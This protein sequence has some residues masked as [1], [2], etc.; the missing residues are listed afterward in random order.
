MTFF[1]SPFFFFFLLLSSSFFPCCFPP[2]LRVHLFSIVHVV[3][4]YHDRK[5]HLPFPVTFFGKKDY[6]DGLFEPP[7]EVTCV[8]VMSIKRRVM[9]VAGDGLYDCNETVLK[10]TMLISR[11]QV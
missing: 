9:E 5:E 6:G 3:Y 4:L 7:D 8:G 2:P 1:F 11:T 10:K